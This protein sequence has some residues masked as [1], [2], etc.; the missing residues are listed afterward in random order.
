MI[1]IFEFLPTTLGLFV[2]NVVITAIAYAV[3]KKRETRT[4]SGQGTCNN[5]AFSPDGKVEI[6]KSK[7]AKSPFA[8]FAVVDASLTIFAGLWVF[9]FYAADQSMASGILLVLYLTNF[10]IPAA[11]M[12]VIALILYLVTKGKSRKNKHILG[13]IKN[14]ALE[15]TI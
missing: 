2:V 14:A 12:F 7:M 3:I 15:G 13:R 10:L 9:G 8:I 11:V 4:Q 1:D 6:S 5:Q